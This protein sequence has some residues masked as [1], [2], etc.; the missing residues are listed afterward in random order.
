VEYQ[1]FRGSDVHEALSAV[2]D[3]LGSDA[4]IGSTRRV[5]NGRAGAFG[6]TY[7]EIMAAPGRSGGGA[8][9]AEMTDSPARPQRPSPSRERFVQRAPARATQ[10]NLEQEIRQL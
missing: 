8:T 4:L 9:A 7:V 2:R 6:H 3:A 5:T 1:T 10:E